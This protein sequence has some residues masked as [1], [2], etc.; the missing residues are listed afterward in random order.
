MRYT[1]DRFEDNIAVLEA[2]DRTTVSVERSILPMDCTEGTVLL[3]T[4]DGFVRDL[5]EELAR[6]NRIKE[7]MKRLWK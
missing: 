7:K 5:E 3:K 1:I 6:A 2:E 4:A